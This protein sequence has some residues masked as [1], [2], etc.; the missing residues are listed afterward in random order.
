MFTTPVDG[1]VID[2]LHNNGQSVDSL[3][4]ENVKHIVHNVLVQ[5]YTVY[6]TKFTVYK[7]I[8]V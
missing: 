1:F 2:G 5:N 6:Y 7:I 3:S 4:F 8:I